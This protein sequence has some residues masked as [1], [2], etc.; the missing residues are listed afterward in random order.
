MQLDPNARRTAYEKACELTADGGIAVGDYVDSILSAYIEAAPSPSPA[1][2]VVTEIR[3]KIE[4][5]HVKVS[6]DD[7][8]N[9]AAGQEYGLRQ[10]LIIVDAALASLS[11]PAKGA[12]GGG[13]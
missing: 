13:L 2:G 11:Q 1:P 12:K 8:Y 10:A 9:Y 7:G 6:G 5:E 4:A 3:A